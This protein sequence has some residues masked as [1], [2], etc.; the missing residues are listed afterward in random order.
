MKCCVPG[1]T[2]VNLTINGVK[3]RT[4]SF[5]RFPLDKNQAKIWRTILDI[6]TVNP[7]DKVCEMHFSTKYLLEMPDKKKRLDWQAIPKRPKLVLEPPKTQRASVWDELTEIVAD[8]KRAK[9]RY[10]K[11]LGIPNEFSDD[12]DDSQYFGIHFDGLPWW[13][14]P[15]DPN[16]VKK[17][18]ESNDPV[19]K[20]C[21]ICGVVVINLDFHMEEHFP[22]TQPVLL[23]QE[24]E[25]GEIPNIIE[26]EDIIDH[27]YNDDVPESEEETETK[28]G[29]NKNYYMCSCYKVLS[30]VEGLVKH[31]AQA[32]ASGSAVKHD[33]VCVNCPTKFSDFEIYRKHIDANGTLCFKSVNPKKEINPLV[34][35][36]MSRKIMLINSDKDMQQCCMCGEVYES[37]HAYMKHMRTVHGP[38]VKGAKLASSHTNFTELDELYTREIE[39]QQVKDEKMKLYNEMQIPFVFMNDFNDKEEFGEHDGLPWWARPIITEV[40]EKKKKTPKKS[41]KRK[42]DEVKEEKNSEE[43][44]ENEN[45]KEDEE[46][47]TNWPGRSKDRREMCHICG[48]IRAHINKHI[49]LHQMKKDKC[50]KCNQAITAEEEHKCFTPTKKKERCMCSCGQ[51]FIYPEALQGH[52][53]VNTDGNH[54]F[55]CIKCPFICDTADEFMPHE[56][57]HVGSHKCEICFKQFTTR[58]NLR[59]HLKGVHSNNR[60]FKCD[61]CAQSFKSKINLAAHVER[62]HQSIPVPCPYCDKM[63]KEG[64]SLNNHIIRQHEKRRD[65]VCEVCQRAFNNIGALKYHITIHTGE[66]AF[67]CP[68]CPQAFKSN[69]DLRRHY[70]NHKDLTI[71]CP[72]CKNHFLNE[73]ELKMH[74]NKYHSMGNPEGFDE[75]VVYHVDEYEI[76]EGIIEEVA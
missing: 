47:T 52:I 38:L 64:L 76:T 74:Y 57:T 25:E 4:Y 32:E 56:Q 39:L 11:Y 69:K 70:V 58:Q 24:L 68:F 46:Q 23:S 49:M 18:I 51:A 12:F 13:A 5:F 6:S 63:Y 22:H 67:S 9:E 21:E 2:S 72:M 59:N 15:V 37:G 41:L 7:K 30:T 53:S 54:R 43:E 60:P 73:D 66:R 26:D 45:E 65:F 71:K 28:V 44:N 10:F 19:E 75:D 40:P 36:G 42:L 3:Q 50:S 55:K 35:L 14:R 62:V 61:Q 48:H 16:V 1:C 8:Y 31:I 27:D 33:L 29:S 17:E 34:N 20:I